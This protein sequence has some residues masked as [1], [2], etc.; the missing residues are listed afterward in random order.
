MAE[1]FAAGAHGIIAF[2]R[3]EETWDGRWTL[4]LFTLGERQREVRGGERAYP[5]A[6]ECQ[7][8]DGTLSRPRQ[9]DRRAANH[10]QEAQTGEPPIES[11][12][13]QGPV[14]RTR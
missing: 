8:Q 14:T 13:H 11:A 5:P 7:R 3:S 1:E 9:G 4:A 12:V 10:P 6:P 2:G